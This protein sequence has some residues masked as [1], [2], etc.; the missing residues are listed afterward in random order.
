MKRRSFIKGL[1]LTAAASSMV[2][3][4]LQAASK[5]K[6][7][8][9]M[10]FDQAL[11]VLTDGKGAKAS[12][13][14]KL[15]VPEIAENGAVVP[16]K[17]EIDSPMSDKDFVKSIHVYASK[18]A[19]VRC[20]DVQLSPANGK[21]YFA[22]RVKLAGTQEVVAVAQLSNGEFIKSAKNVK[23]TIGGCG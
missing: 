11:N 12:S 8:N 4:A 2:P 1:A 22:T 18:N 9:A 10:S 23:V 7:P 17:V 15:T 3:T 21:A 20:A 14:M 19:N 5:P 16:V 6:S 13:K